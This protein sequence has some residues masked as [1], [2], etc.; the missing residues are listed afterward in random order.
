MQTGIATQTIT[1]QTI[2]TQTDFFGHME[3][4]T[5][6]SPLSPSVLPKKSNEEKQH[7]RKNNITI[8][9]GTI[10]HNTYENDKSDEQNIYEIKTIVEKLLNIKDLTTPQNSFLREISGPAPH[11]EN[12]WDWTNMYLSDC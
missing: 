9:D 2:T 8:S 6:L 3:G 12:K 11:G 1:T 4:V 5:I 10:I 7:K